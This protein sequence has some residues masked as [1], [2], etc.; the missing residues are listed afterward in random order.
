MAIA[1][2]TQ[3]QV[4]TAALEAADIQELITAITSVV[5]LPGGETPDKVFAINIIVQPTGT[6]TINV[7][8][9]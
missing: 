6:G 2:T 5:T 1:L 4:A 9:K 8:F 3:P 7:R